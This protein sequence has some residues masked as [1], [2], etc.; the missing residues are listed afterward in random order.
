LTLLIH[1]G[2]VSHAV[3]RLTETV[4]SFAC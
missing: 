4:I 3:P 2:S 1:F